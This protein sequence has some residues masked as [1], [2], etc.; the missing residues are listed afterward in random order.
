MNN[1]NPFLE[2]SNI[3]SNHGVIAFP[4][5]TVMGLGVF[6][7]DYEAYLKLNVIKK[8]REDKPYTMMVKDIDSIQKYAYVD[9]KIMRVISRFMPGPI[10]ILLKAK[11]NVPSYVTHGTGI[12]GIRIPLNKEARDL[13]NYLDKPLLVPS[14]NRADQTPA[15]NSEEAINIF[16]EEVGYYI[17]G[18]ATSHTPSTIV[19]LAAEQI[20]LI[21]QGELSFD[22]IKCVYDGHKYE[23]TVICYILKDNNVLMMYR[24]KKEK[25]INKNKWIGVG[26]HVEIG[27]TPEEAIIRE[28]KEE[29]TLTLNSC[30]RKAEIVFFFKEDV[31]VMHVFTSDNYDG[32]VNFDCNEGTLNWIPLKELFSLQ[33]WEGDRIFLEPVLNNNPFFKMKMY[34]EGDKLIKYKEVK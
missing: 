34:Y 3:L 30:T 28:I 12:I 23:E 27:E 17:E 29:T 21:R 2:A 20:S 31:E 19:N 6:F 7:D 15:Y 4:T 11:D 32:E 5:E 9:E 8:R 22:A 1:V 25:D 14:A 18:K 16:G 10:T 33:L 26:G 13:L 24:N